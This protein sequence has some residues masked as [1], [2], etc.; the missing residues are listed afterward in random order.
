M[1]SLLY[2]IAWLLHIRYRTLGNHVSHR[3]GFSGVFTYYYNKT[4]VNL[5]VRFGREVHY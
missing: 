1:K 5:H 4:F 2:D 3:L